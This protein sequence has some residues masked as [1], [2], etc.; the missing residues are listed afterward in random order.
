MTEASLKQVLL[1]TDRLHPND[2][3]PNAMTT[4]EF[5]ELVEEV[6]HLGRLP[7]PVVVRPNETGYQ[8]VD[9]EHGWRAAQEAGLAEVAC[10]VVEVD[11]FEAM[12][13]TYKRNQHGTHNKVRLGQMFRWMMEDKGLSQRALAE[14]INVSE[15]TV[16]NAL[17]YAKASDVRN[18]YAF[19]E[20][21]TRQVRYFNRLPSKIGSLWL[22]GGADPQTYYLF[23]ENAICVMTTTICS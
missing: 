5:T 20:L 2:Y 16:R 4:E 21:T 9:G 23:M 11:D 10:E 3:N 1:P 8:I 13:Q 15:G 7:K 19:D 6:Q 12:R 22:D 14:E 18:D 17:E